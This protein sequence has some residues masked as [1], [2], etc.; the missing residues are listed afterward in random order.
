[1][2]QALNELEFIVV[3]DI[4]PSA[5]AEMAHL[6]LPAASDFERHA[7]GAWPGLQGDYVA[8]QQKVIAPV[9]KSRNV[10]E[11]EYALAKRLGV[12]ERFPWSSNEGWIDYKLSPLGVTF[13]QLLKEHIIYVSPG[14][15]Y[16]KYRTAGFK[17]DSGKVELFSQKLADIGQDPMPVFSPFPEKPDL[18]KKYPL[19]GTTRKPGNY[20]HTRFRDVVRLRQLQPKPLVRIHPR[21][22]QL[23]QIND[24]DLTTISS[25]EG[26]IQ[27]TALVTDETRIGQIIVDFGWGNSWDGGANVNVLTCDHLRCPLSGATPNRRFDCEVKKFNNKK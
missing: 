11:V 22:A 21:D 17:T 13:D 26:T 18:G 24:Q 12:H 25:P 15:K 6:I 4:L 20:V 14:L 2:R 8:L 7:Y 23:R 1:M 19:I 10:F 3:Y 5:T 27:A 16:H 9:G